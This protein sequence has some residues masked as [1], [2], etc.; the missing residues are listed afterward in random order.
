MASFKNNYIVCSCNNVSLGEIVHSI[1]IKKASTLDEIGEITEAGT[2][3]E[4]CKN[5][6]CDLSVRKKELYFK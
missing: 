2:T 1:E 5:E 6:K 3:C 4:Y